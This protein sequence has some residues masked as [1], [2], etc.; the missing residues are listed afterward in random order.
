MK[1]NPRSIDL[2]NQGGSGRNQYRAIAPAPQYQYPA[3][4]PAQ[5]YY[6]QEGD[7]YDMVDP[8]NP[9]VQY[10][11]VQRVEPFW[12]GETKYSTKFDYLGY[13]LRL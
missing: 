11:S 12:Q 8:N 7:G 1:K 10:V 4:D 5:Q 3:P 2:Y 6:G 13:V 9:P